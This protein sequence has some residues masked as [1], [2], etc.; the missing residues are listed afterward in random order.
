M[1]PRRIELIPLPARSPS[2]LWLVLAILIG[3]MLLL[4]DLAPKRS[5]AANHSGIADLG[6]IARQAT[7]EIFRNRD[8]IAIDRFFSEAFVQH[9]PNIADGLSGLK[10]FAADV[11]GSPVADVTIY[12]TL[13]DGDIVML[14]S[15]YDRL[16]GF[17]GPVIAFDLFR[18][19]GG[20]IVEHWGGQ[21][22]EVG[23]NPSGH[24]QVDGPTAVVDRDRTEANRALV[25]A[26]KQVVTVE[27]RFDRLG[28]FI[29]GDNYTQHASKVGDGVARMKSRVSGVAKPGAA[30][31][32]VP[33]RYVA[34]GNFVLA[35]VEAR[36]EP[37]TA[38]YDL[39]RVQSGKIAEHWDV[40]SPIPPRNQW[41]NANGPF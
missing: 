40:L 3:G 32:L 31:V 2:R 20:K 37:P 12:R 19:E 7:I 15:K 33:R 13:V 5:K 36:T 34:E 8:L 18:F 14:H 24:T 28:E 21:E 1:A 39:F 27:L 23:P 9:D 29:D 25:R 30:P 17:A 10:A 38:N 11:A 26:F 4:S 22:P 6:A 16:R 41:K 35:V